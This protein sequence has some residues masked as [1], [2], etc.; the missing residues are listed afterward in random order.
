MT[1]PSIETSIWMALKARVQTLPGGYTIA[2]P[3]A[4][5]TPPQSTGPAPVHLPYIECRN[6]PN[7]TRRA[8]I[9]STDPHD[10]KGILQLT[11]CW[12]VADIKPAKNAKTESDVLVAIAGDIA[13]H[14]PTDLRLTFSGVEVRIMNAPSILND[15]MLEGIYIKIP[16]SVNWQAYA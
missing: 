10:R 16:I 12:P 7:R 8:F 1:G 13:A 9:G 5:F 3:R 4:P 11:L 15:G 6:I 14:F 2:W